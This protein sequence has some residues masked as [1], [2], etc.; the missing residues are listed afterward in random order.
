LTVALAH[1][2]GLRVIAEGIETGEQLLRLQA[3]GCEYGQGYLFSEPLTLEA[4]ERMLA[5][6]SGDRVA[7]SQ[8]L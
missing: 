8:A 7:L 5:G 4:T 6:W 3:L 2:L 1:S